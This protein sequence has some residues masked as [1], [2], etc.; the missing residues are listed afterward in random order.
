M[1]IGMENTVTLKAELTISITQTTNHFCDEQCTLT[2]EEDHGIAYQSS[3]SQIISVM[4]RAH[5]LKDR[6]MK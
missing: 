6:I 2:Q 4:D 3:H 5:S 1:F